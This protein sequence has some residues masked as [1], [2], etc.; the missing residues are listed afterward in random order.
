MVEHRSLR[1]YQIEE[2]S[3]EKV[4]EERNNIIHS[5]DKA[6]RTKRAVKN[7]KKRSWENLRK[8]LGKSCKKDNRKLEQDEDPKKKPGGQ[9]WD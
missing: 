2:T 6:D 8:K 4:Q 3:M 1:Q 9:I 5:R 7:Q